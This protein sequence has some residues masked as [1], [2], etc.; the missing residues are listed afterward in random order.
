MERNVQSIERIFSV[1]ELIAESYSGFGI[2]EISRKLELP[3]STVH[4]IVNSLADRNYLVKNKTSEKFTLGYKLIAMAGDYVSRLDIRTVAAPFISELSRKHEV[5]SHLAVR[6]GERAVYIEKMEP[7][8]GICNY[9]E[10]GKSIELY[11]SGLGKALLIGYTENELEK[12]TESLNITQHTEFTVDKDELLQQI[13]DAKISNIT[14]DNQEHEE[15]VYCMASPIFDYSNKVI[16]AISI[17]SN[18]KDFLSNQ[19]C[20]QAIIGAARKISA[21]YGKRI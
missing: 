19:E 8:S 2:S 16:A 20:R 21:L 14:F 15:G 4:R 9:S 13:S 18:D 1:L 10:I 3:K 12:Y 7:Y 5:S 6:Q 11:C 17:S